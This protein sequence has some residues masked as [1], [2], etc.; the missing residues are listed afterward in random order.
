V[1]NGIQTVLVIFFAT[2]FGGEKQKSETGDKTL[3]FREVLPYPAKIPCKKDQ[4]ESNAKVVQLCPDY[5]P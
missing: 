5:N 3:M 1:C 4:M 2:G